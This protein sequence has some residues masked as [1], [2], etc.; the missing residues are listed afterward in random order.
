VSAEGRPRP[1]FNHEISWRL[2]PAA[3]IHTA[4][5][6]RQCAEP[7]GYGYRASNKKFLH[8]ITPELVYYF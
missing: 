7:Q 4:R 3:R 6:C 1:V 5:M 8:E 2:T